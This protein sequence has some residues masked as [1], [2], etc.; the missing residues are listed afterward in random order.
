MNKTCIG[1]IRVELITTRRLPAKGNGCVKNIV[2]S[3][4]VPEQPVINQNTASE[5]FR[6]TTKHDT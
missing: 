6:S 3:V 5:N 1:V 4:P 2:S